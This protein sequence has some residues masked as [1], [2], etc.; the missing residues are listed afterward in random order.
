MDKTLLF[1]LIIFLITVV[2]L[3]LILLVVMA[4]KSWMSKKG[5]PSP[6]DQAPRP[7]TNGR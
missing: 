6:S 3:I 4:M 1:L 5:D 7:R 2:P